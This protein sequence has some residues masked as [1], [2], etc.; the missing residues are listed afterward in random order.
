MQTLLRI[1][2]LCTIWLACLPTPAL[3]AQSI[4]IGGFAE[5]CPQSPDAPGCPE[6]LAQAAAETQANTTAVAPQTQSSGSLVPVQCQSPETCG[7]CEFVELI[8]NVIRFLITFA[9]IAATLM[10]IYGGFQLVISGG[11]TAAKQAA[12]S[13]IVNVLIGFVLVLAAFLVINTILG[14]LLPGDSRVLGWQRIECIYPNVPRSVGYQEYTLDG[15]NDILRNTRNRNRPGSTRDFSRFT[16]SGVCASEFLGGYFGSQAS[17][18]ACVVQGESA[19]GASLVS[20]T[21]LVAN[22]SDAFSFGAFQINISVHEVQG[23]AGIGADSNYLD[24]KTAF[25]G[26]NYD[27][28]VVDRDLYNA[29]AAALMNPECSAINASRLQQRDG[30]GIWSAYGANN[31]G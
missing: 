6:F 5:C 31:C 24:C 22:R 2:L 14:L 3:E 4:C 27:A 13:I 30:W 7:T 11:N 16:N 28:T 1:F 17:V 10:L 12:K 21:D 26:Q 25:S 20:R 23:C 29:C 19:C 9:T 18:A 15:V 8:N